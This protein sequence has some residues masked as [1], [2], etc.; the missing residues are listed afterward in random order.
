MA[1]GRPGSAS[2][3]HL[4]CPAPWPLPRNG[5]RPKA[6]SEQ[7]VGTNRKL[8]KNQHSHPTPPQPS[9]NPTLGLEQS[10]V[11]EAKCLL[12]PCLA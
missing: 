7:D 5:A 2:T 10:N 1:K 8:Q 3:L 12:A 11:Q 4:K 6:E 9:L